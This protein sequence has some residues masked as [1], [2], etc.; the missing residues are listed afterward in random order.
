METLARRGYRFI[1]PVESIGPGVAAAKPELAPSEQTDS[2]AGKPIASSTARLEP[3][4]SKE[5]APAQATDANKKFTTLVLIG[6][7]LAAAATVAF[8]WSAHRIVET[9]GPLKLTRLTSDAGLTT[10]GAISPDGKLVAYASDRGGQGNLDIWIK[11]IAGGEAI[12]LTRDPADDRQPHFCR[13]GSQI[14]FR[15]ERGG[16]GIYVIATLGSTEQLL[17]NE[18]R[19]PRFSPDGKWVT[20]WVGMYWAPVMDN[21]KG[22]I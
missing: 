18:G 9:P 12:Q 5:A 19:S 13:D 15:S 8:W 16:G 11:H 3:I 21:A 1:A 6:L 20:Y 4:G 7:L 14:V 10:D 17:A 2:L 22:K